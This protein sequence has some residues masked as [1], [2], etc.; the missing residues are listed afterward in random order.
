MKGKGITK[1]NAEKSQLK[2]KAREPGARA[3]KKSA[4]AAAVSS[5]GVESG[6]SKVELIKRPREYSV[7]FSFPE[8]SMISPPILEVKDVHFR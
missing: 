8:V 4:A 6:E 2:S 7:R 1:E 3:Q 5:G